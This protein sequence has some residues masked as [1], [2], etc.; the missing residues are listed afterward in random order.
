M[1]N[2]LYNIKTQTRIEDLV[3]S[4]GEACGTKVILEI[5]V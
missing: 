5:P 3:D 2:Q 4:Y 1:I